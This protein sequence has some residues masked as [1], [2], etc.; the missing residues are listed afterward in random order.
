M[1]SHQCPQLAAMDIASRQRRARPAHLLRCV[2]PL[3][4]AMELAAAAKRTRPAV[5]WTEGRGSG[6]HR[7]S[8]AAQLSA[9]VRPGQSLGFV[10]VHNVTFCSCG[11][12][13]ALRLIASLR[14][15]VSATAD[16]PVLGG[17]P[18]LAPASSPLSRSTNP[19]MCRRPP[20]VSE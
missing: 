4:N 15:P 9:V 6:G 1:S 20:G 17:R 10:L 19:N 8:L 14:F 12:N 2:R 16:T 5:C 7:A 18:P 13:A 11:A 3:A